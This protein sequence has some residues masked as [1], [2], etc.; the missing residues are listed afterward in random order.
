MNALIAYLLS[1]AVVFVGI[2]TRPR[3]AQCPS[4]WWMNG[5]RPSGEFGCRP[6]PRLRASEEARGPYHPEP[7]DPDEDVEVYGHVFC[8]PGDEPRVMSDGVHV[9]CWRKP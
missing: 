5:A 4:G 3:S 1:V 9:A 2:V 6:T 8:D 7:L